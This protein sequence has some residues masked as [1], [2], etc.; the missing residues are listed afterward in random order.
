MSVQI[1]P[2][3]FRMQT[4]LMFNNSLSLCCFFIPVSRAK[5]AGKSFAFIAVVEL[6]IQRIFI[7]SFLAEVRR[8]SRHENQRKMQN[9]LIAKHYGE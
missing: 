5:K 7:C 4:F 1:C 6:E 3:K 2:H 8:R 9:I